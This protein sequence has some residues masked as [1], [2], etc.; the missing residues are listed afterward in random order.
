MAPPGFPL[1]GQF[2]TQASKILLDAG[3]DP[4]GRDRSGGT[5]LMHA[6]G[7]GYDEEVKLLLEYHADLNLKDSRGRTALMYAAEGQYVDAIPL[8][9]ARGADPRWR[10][11]DGQS[12]SRSREEIRQQ[13]RD[14]ASGIRLGSAR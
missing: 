1:L 10:N 11:V 14:R 12:R 4:N 3:A 9:L 7:Q 8:L 6:S 2:D 13:G 5:A